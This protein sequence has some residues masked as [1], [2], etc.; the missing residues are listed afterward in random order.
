MKKRIVAIALAVLMLFSLIPMTALA[1]NV[2][3]STN[4][5]VTINGVTYT[6]SSGTL[7]VSGSGT[8]TRDWK[9]S[10]TKSQVTSLYIEG[11]VTAI[12]MMA[13]ED[14]TNLTSISIGTRVTK[15][16]DRAFAGC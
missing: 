13:F 5:S 6:L 7:T 1:A 15:I 14:C 3:T 4:G 12:D 11:S 10:F 9:N 8:C 2:G 16:G